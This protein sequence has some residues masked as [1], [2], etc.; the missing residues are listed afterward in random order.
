MERALLLGLPLE[1][2][3][4]VHRRSIERSWSLIY[5]ERMHH[6]WK[7]SCMKLWRNESNEKELSRDFEREREQIWEGTRMLH[8]ISLPQVSGQFRPSSL[9]VYLSSLFAVRLKMFHGQL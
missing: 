8:P 4:L 5:I 2:R 7:G 6:F 1:L 3:R 9:E